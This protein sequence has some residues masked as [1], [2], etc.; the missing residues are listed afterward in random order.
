TTIYEPPPELSAI[1]WITEWR[2]NWLW[3]AVAIFLAIWYVRAI[4]KLS[5]RGDKWPVQRTIFF[6]IGLA[7]LVG[8]TSAAP[9]IYGLVLFSAHMVNHMILTMLIP[10]F[11]VHGAPITLAMRSMESRKDGTRGPREYMLTLLQ[12]KYSK[13][14]TN[15]IFAAVNF[16]GSLVIFYF[17]PVFEFALRYHIGHEMMNI[18]FLLTGFIFVSVMIGIDPLPNRPSYPLRL[19]ILLATMVFHAFIAVSLTGSDSL[20]MSEWFS[21]IGRDWGASAIEDQQ[22]GGLIMWGTGEFPTVG[23]A[24]IVLFRWRQDDM[25]HAKRRDDRVDRLGDSDLDDLNE[26]YARMAVAN[27]ETNHDP[28]R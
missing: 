13:V 8:D 15:P 24:M 9:A 3:V 26:Y 22:I 12:S 21:A 1:R 11:L 14:I 17:T 5:A 28:N 27:E 10:I 18:H 25:Q 20:L 19:V 16:A 4:R 2:F 6:F 23:M 7:I